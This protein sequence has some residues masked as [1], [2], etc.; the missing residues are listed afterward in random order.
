MAPSLQTSPAHPSPRLSRQTKLAYGLGS[1]SSAVIQNIRVVFL[2][3]F[4]TNVAGLNA[5]WAGT[6]LLIGRIWDGLNDPLVGWLSDRTQSR[7]GKRYPWIVAGA[8]PLG[9]LTFLQW[10]VPPFAAE[11]P[12]HQLYLF[13][14]YTL[15][16]LLFD[17]AF[18]AVIVPFS[19]LVPDLAQDYDERT[20]LV[21]FQVAF[22]IV[23]GIGILL[24]AQI[25]F[26]RV[27]IPTQQYLL[28]GA[29][30]GAIALAAI[31][32]SVWGTYGS[33]RA[34]M[35]RPQADLPT[36]TIWRQVTLIFRQREFQIV[37]G[38]FVLGWVSI[39]GMVAILPYFIQS[40]MQLPVKQVTQL[41]IA[42]QVI[43][44]VGLPLWRRLS[45]RLG[46]RG[47]LLWGLPMAI[48]GELGLS[49][50]HPG[51][52]GLMYGCA[53][54]IGLGL[55][56]VYLMPLAMLPDVIDLD[57]LRHGQRRE[58]L[59]YSLM[60][61]MQKFGLG[62]VL[63]LLSQ[64]LNWGGLIST[65]GDQP[66]P[67]QPPLVLSTIRVEIGL[68]PALVMALALGLA[69]Y[70]PITQAQHQAIQLQLQKK[71]AAR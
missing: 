9:L 49:L 56:T 11:S 18:T 53:I 7:F 63:F 25:I 5:A 39:Q 23:G 62:L 26:A 52:T 51:Q 44:L 57:E 17:T 58:G 70:Y 61:Q 67:V 42:I 24:L 59:F 71:G 21:S 27:P 43:A 33:H 60:M 37:T 50:L 65:T 19:A 36:P 10:V 66:A 31:L 14:Y 35:V 64:G 30:C 6:I 15:I 40:W 54:G 4:L 22:S 34:Q 28:L 20:S 48:V 2:L 32:L 12:Y 41:A 3:Y 47:V 29:S 38:I 1:V 46:K 16:A 45:R 69:W 13:G 55:S 8:I 68:I